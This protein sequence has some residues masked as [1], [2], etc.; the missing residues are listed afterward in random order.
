MLQVK[1]L[2]LLIVLNFLIFNSYTKIYK[3]EI[4]PEVIKTFFPFPEELNE[5]PNV[6]KY[7]KNEKQFISD[8]K[9]KFIAEVTTRSSN[10]YYRFENNYDVNLLL[11][12]LYK[13]LILNINWY[14]MVDSKIYQE[15]LEIKEPY[16]AYSASTS[17]SSD[18]ELETQSE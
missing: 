4:T 2:M 13:K 8:F 11:L 10:E 12:K 16:S 15:K 18:S 5:W 3:I 9:V 6:D 17:D 1:T 7:I 14:F